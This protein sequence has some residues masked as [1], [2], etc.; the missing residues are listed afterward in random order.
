MRWVGRKTRVFRY[1][2]SL[3]LRHPLASITTTPEKFRLEPHQMLLLY[4]ETME[5]PE[6]TAYLKTFC[7]WSNGVRAVLAKYELPYTEKDIIK[8]PGIPFRDGAGDGPAAFA[9]RGG[10]WH[11]PARHQR[12]G[13]RSI[14]VWPTISWATRT[15][16]PTSRSMPRAPTRSTR[17]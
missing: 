4:S 11:A 13:S 15:S 14:P 7:G 3:P 9:L 10:Q 6:I 17:P 5:K 1:S 2:K 8:K 12:R 16:P